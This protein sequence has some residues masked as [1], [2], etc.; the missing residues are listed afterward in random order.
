MSNLARDLA[1]A[2][3]VATSKI[4]DSVVCRDADADADVL[5]GPIMLYC[6]ENPD[7]KVSNCRQA[8]QTRSSYDPVR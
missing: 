7:R 6:Q 5:L 3:S 8:R 2:R 4:F 1:M